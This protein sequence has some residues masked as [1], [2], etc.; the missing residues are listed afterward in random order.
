MVH[1]QKVKNFVIKDDPRR[2]EQFSIPCKTEI[3]RS[4]IFVDVSDDGVKTV[5]IT[6]EH[7]VV[8]DET[9]IHEPYLSN[10]GELYERVSA[11]NL[12]ESVR[13]QTLI[14]AARSLCDN[15]ETVGTHHRVD[16]KYLDAL[17]QAIDRL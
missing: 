15:V 17:R 11:D 9:L 7:F 4:G 2:L 10:K 16:G 8:M 6:A 3:E 1:R 12:Q 5:T 14:A 13:L